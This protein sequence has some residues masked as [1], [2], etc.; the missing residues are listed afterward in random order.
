MPL[1]ARN[2]STNA[3]P[4]AGGVPDDSARR[5]GARRRAAA[6]RRRRAGAGWR[7]PW[8]RPWAASVGE[9]TQHVGAARRAAPDG[10]RARAR[11]ARCSGA[12]PSPRAA[13]SSSDVH[14]TTTPASTRTT[15]PSN[16]VRNDRHVGGAHVAVALRLGEWTERRHQLADVGIVG[17]PRRELDDD[18]PDRERQMGEQRQIES[19]RQLERVRRRSS[20]A[21]RAGSSP[22]A[23]RWCR[24]PASSTRRTDSSGSHATRQVSRNVPLVPRPSSSAP[25][26]TPRATSWW[27][28]CDLASPFG[29][30]RSSSTTATS[31]R[32]F[33]RTR[34]CRTSR[35]RASGTCGAPGGTSPIASPTISRRRTSGR[36][37]IDRVGGV[38][39]L[40]ETRTRA[41]AQDRQRLGH[42]RSR[43]S[44][45]RAR[46]PCRRRA[47]GGRCRRRSG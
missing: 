30:R 33:S 24:A 17:G 16:T 28:R 47:A 5:A 25:H 2:P 21:R 40:V 11:P 44:G 27:R 23:R 18:R 6:S 4:T 35:S 10:R 12:R 43:R 37:P 7:R 9:L 36:P 39:H 13:S 45:G 14:A 8:T 1:P 42:P 34:R 19:R 22:P 26:P 20:P 15:R 38:E 41:A 32:G 3:A 29:V 46:R 31:E